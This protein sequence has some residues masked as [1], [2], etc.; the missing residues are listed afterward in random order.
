MTALGSLKDPVLWSLN[1][2][3]HAELRLLQQS[4]YQSPCSVT[5][6]YHH[7]V[8]ELLDLLHCILRLL[9]PCTALERRNTSVFPVL[10]FLPVWPHAA[11]NQQ[12]ACWKPCS[13]DETDQ[14]LQLPPSDTPRPFCDDCPSN[15]YRPGVLDLWSV[16][17]LGAHECVLGGL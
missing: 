3:A 16:H 4:V 6:E 8:F 2:K 7:N 13:E 1:D 10:I 11:E 15:S 17:P 9:T 5:R 12:S 14:V